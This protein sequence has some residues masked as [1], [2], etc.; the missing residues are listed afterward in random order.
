[1]VE[2][3]DAA[4]DR[5]SAA[6]KAELTDELIFLEQVHP[7][8]NNALFKVRVGEDVYLLK[9]VQMTSLIV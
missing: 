4:A 3:G 7:T 1:M 2:E 5:G 9:M 8:G 6:A